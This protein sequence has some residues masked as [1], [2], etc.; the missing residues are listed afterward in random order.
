M[1]HMKICTVAAAA[2]RGGSANVARNG[3]SE[4]YDK[5]RRYND[6]Q[7]SSTTNVDAFS[8]GSGWNDAVCH[9]CGVPAN[10]TAGL[11]LP[12]AR[13]LTEDCGG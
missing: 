9:L 12:C 5:W 6:E 8:A 2:Q 4:C 7:S 1:A 13:G 10:A 3:I 11:C